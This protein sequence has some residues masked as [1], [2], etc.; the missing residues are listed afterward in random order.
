MQEVKIAIISNGAA[1][2]A[3]AL[4]QYIDQGYTIDAFSTETPSPTAQT[5]TLL[6]VVHRE[7]AGQWS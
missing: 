3:Q 6:V 2:T 7:Q 1:P 4:K 5:K